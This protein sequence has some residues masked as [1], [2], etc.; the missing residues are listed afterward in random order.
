MINKKKLELL[1]IMISDAP[2]LKLT[3][4]TIAGG[5]PIKELKVLVEIRCKDQLI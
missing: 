2:K 1:K 5:A 4:Q 3:E